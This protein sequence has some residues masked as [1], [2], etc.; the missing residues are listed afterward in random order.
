MQQ[1][2]SGEFSTRRGAELAVEQLVQEYGIDRAAIAVTARGAANSSGSEVA[3]AD[4]E[5]GHPGVEKQSSPK[6]SGAIDVSISC[7]KSEEPSVE[8]A[9]K[10]TG[11]QRI[12]KG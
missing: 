6:L 4:A 8:A 2:I 9:L 10:K 11:A 3:G 5:S 1:A 12:V 7:N